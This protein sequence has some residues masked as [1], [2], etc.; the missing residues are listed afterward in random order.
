MIA[1]IR[2]RDVVLV[3]GPRLAGV[4]GVAAALRGRLSWL[5]VV[6]SGDLQPGDAPKGVVFVVSAAAL[7]AQSDCTRLDVAAVATDVVIGVVAK[8]DVHRNWRD[9]L[10]ADRDML[11]AYATRYHQV[12]W[13]GVA[14]APQLGPSRVDDL[15]TVLR[16]QL[17]DPEA[18]RR[19]SLRATEARLAALV[20]TYAG[21]VAGPVRRAQ[22]AALRT[23]REAILRRWRESK[24]ENVLALRSQIQRTRIQL[25]YSADNQC[26]ALRGELRHD[27]A[28]LG[29]QN[30]S[31]FD[32]YARARIG[33]TII[34]VAHRIDEQMAQISQT[35]GFTGETS[36]AAEAAIVDIPPPPLS[37]RR[38]ETRLVLLLGVGFGLGVAL[39]VS[40]L[41]A[42][43]VSGLTAAGVTAGAAIGL[44]FAFGMVRIRGLLDD[45][46]VLDRWLGEVTESLR[47]AMHHQVAT[48]M[49]DLELALRGALHQREEAESLR[50]RNLIST[51]DGEL[52][53]QGSAAVRMAKLRDREVS[54]LRAALTAVRVALGEP[55]PRKSTAL[56]R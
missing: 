45:R 40:R 25:C 3:D 6:E 53:T 20:Q 28:R 30:L 56:G 4:S 23:Q 12:P 36:C 55:G 54:R 38:L 49:L 48:R 27:T 39:T 47:L 50:I 16:E 10:T 13:I 26:V 43:L 35:L 32:A 14:A 5:T 22:V 33:E 34:A 46:L 7:L 29:R 1:G 24:S 37:V 18:D 17:A 21:D 41:L 15:I 8:I 31:R 44:A 19:N 42:S 2:R 9:V 52:R 11:A 51:I